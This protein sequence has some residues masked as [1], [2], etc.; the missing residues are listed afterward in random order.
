MRPENVDILEGTDKAQKNRHGIV[1]RYDG[2]TIQGLVLLI[3]GRGARWSAINFSSAGT[4]GRVSL[5]VWVPLA[6]ASCASH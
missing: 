1:V 2:V 6:F 3:E 4:F 5:S